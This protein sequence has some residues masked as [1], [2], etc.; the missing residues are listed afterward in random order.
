M[1]EWKFARAL[2]VDSELA[3][4][5]DLQIGLTDCALIIQNFHVVQL[6]R[7]FIISLL[8]EIHSHADKRKLNVHHILKYSARIALINVFSLIIVQI[9]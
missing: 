4:W 7:Y 2:F 9:I 3:E 1:C 6:L 8:H 5:K